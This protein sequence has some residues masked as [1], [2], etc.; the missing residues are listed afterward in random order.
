MMMRIES[1]GEAV[2]GVRPVISRNDLALTSVKLSERAPVGIS[3]ATGLEDRRFGMQGG[4]DNHGC[5]SLEDR[6]DPVG[7][8]QQEASCV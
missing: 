4:C 2:D 3:A 8:F 5:R 7:G 1:A 6:E